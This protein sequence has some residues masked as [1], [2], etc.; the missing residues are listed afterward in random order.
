MPGLPELPIDVDVSVQQEN[1]GDYSKN[2]WG[3]NRGINKH[4]QE[5]KGDVPPVNAAIR[6]REVP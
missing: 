4:K 3:S 2:R 1:G 5:I 6:Y